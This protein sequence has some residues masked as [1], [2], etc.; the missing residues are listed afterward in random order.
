MLSYL[1]SSEPHYTAATNTESTVLVSS[2]SFTV[3]S[4]LSIRFDETGVEWLLKQRQNGVVPSLEE[5]ATHLTDT[6]TS[7]AATE[8]M[9]SNDTD[10][11]LRQL[12]V[13]TLALSRIAW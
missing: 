9:N 3:F 5:L 7:T 2:S 4:L 12:A 8:H 11:P 13:V 6:L 1:T 10:T